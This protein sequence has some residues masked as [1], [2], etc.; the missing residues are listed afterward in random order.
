MKK[1]LLSACLA[2][3]AIA[4]PACAQVPR[5]AADATR[6]PNFLGAT[7]LLYTPDAYTIGNLR[8][9]AYFH[10]NSDFYGGGATAGI[11]DRFEIGAA[12]IKGDGANRSI[13]RT[14]D[15]EF[16]PNAKLNLLKEGILLPALSVGVIDPFS[17]LKSDASWYVVASK[18]ITPGP[19]RN[20]FSLKANVGYGDGIYDDDV[21]AGLEFVFNRR[22]G[23]MAE[24][25]D[26]KWNF[27]GRFTWGGLGLTVG[28]FDTKHFGGG[29]SYTLRL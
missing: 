4:G 15:T 13:F 1:H 21:F 11:T 25:H 23:A 29:L 12:G 5:P 22:L 10:A 7:G 17:E 18:Y 20:L 24:F 28:L 27:G 14:N 19:V 6:S 3:L 8:G 9:S 2:V 26:G 16:V